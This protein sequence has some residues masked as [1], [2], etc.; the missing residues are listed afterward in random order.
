M[1]FKSL[2]NLIFSFQ[3]FKMLTVFQDNP[4]YN[5]RIQTLVD[6]I[7]KDKF[8]R[9]P[10]KFA[11]QEQ[12]TNFSLGLIQRIE[13]EIRNKLIED[14]NEKYKLVYVYYKDTACSTCNQLGVKDMVFKCK[15]AE[16]SF[17]KS[18]N[19]QH[20]EP[21]VSCDSNLVKKYNHKLYNLIKN[22]EI[23]SFKFTCNVSCDSKLPNL[24]EISVTEK[25]GDNF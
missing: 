12:F 24:T 11:H 17:Y 15:F 2:F 18:D 1:L 22:L 21:S 13:E 3:S 20:T 5:I 6:Y 23:A 7:P 10:F 25:P 4:T 14:F 19:T 16:L 9:A 8:L